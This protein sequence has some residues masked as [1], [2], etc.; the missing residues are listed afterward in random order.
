[1]NA[2]KGS[3]D[4]PLRVTAR[5]A[6]GAD[7]KIQY[8]PGF[9]IPPS[10]YQAWSMEA[11][12][13]VMAFRAGPAAASNERWDFGTHAIPHDDRLNGDAVYGNAKSYN[14]PP[15]PERSNRRNLAKIVSDANGSSSRGSL[16]VWAVLGALLATT[17][18]SL[19]RLSSDESKALCTSISFG[20]LF[21]ELYGI[22]V[23]VVGLLIGT[24]QRSPEQKR[25]V[26]ALRQ[27]KN[28][29]AGKR[30]L[31]SLLGCIPTI[32][33]FVV[34]LGAVSQMAVLA[35]YV[36]LSMDKSVAY[37]MTIALAIV[38][39]TTFIAVGLTLDQDG[40]LCCSRR[41]L[42]HRHKNKRVTK[43]QKT[44]ATLPISDRRPRSPCSPASSHSGKYVPD[45][46]LDSGT[47]SDNDD[48]PRTNQPRADWMDEA[49]KDVIRSPLLDMPKRRR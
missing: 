30:I 42:P 25:F 9:Y 20:G 17:Q 41:S 10:G 39:A 38:L 49:L 2:T 32:C 23:A 40:N 27:A 36:S 26:S 31:S 4:D 6:G 33:G 44:E 47:D 43:G 48:D 12:R 29:N 45:Y 14:H 18:M 46:G 28:G 22:F 5:C 35:L 16:I 24:L 11:N 34:S 3:Y 21:L 15:D 1:M 7:A 19:L 8:G 13:D 37:S